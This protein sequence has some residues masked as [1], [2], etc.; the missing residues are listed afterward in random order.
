M[1]SEK[2]HIVFFRRTSMTALIAVYLLILV[3]GIVRSTG[4]GMGCPDWPKCF[5]T[6]IPPTS[7]SQLSETYKEDFVEYRKQKNQRFANY[8]YA[9]GF[10][11]KADQVLN[12][13]S[14]LAE[15]E[16]NMSKTWTEYINRLIGAIIGL[17]I[18]L[19][20]VAALPYY[21][22]DKSLFTL[23]LLLV[24]LVVFQGWIGS[25]VVS[26]NLLPW[27][28]TVHMLLA[29]LI[30][31][32]LI[33]LVHRIRSGQYVIQ[34]FPKRKMLNLL[35]V[36][37]GILVVTQILFGTQVREAIDAV[38]LSLDF[39][40]RD[41]WVEL[42]GLPFMVHRS[43]SILLVA[44]QAVILYILFKNRRSEGRLPGYA[45]FVMALIVLE[46]LTGIVMAYFGIPPFAQP[47]HLVVAMIIFGIQFMMIL[48]INTGKNEVGL[49]IQI[50]G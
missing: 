30:L 40:E 3:G 23:S 1:S 16:F 20:F 10:D 8:L 44:I 4:S 26:T 15:T 9:L 5:G 39:Q 31:A 24:V 41:T 34:T 36:L 6:W 49:N 12:E 17:L 46:A 2:T 25:V 38:S 43:F 50:T 27:M 22:N 18:L 14:V 35:L 19:N 42:A 33:F 28:V 21:K 45:T 29:M 11:Q 48:I 13:Q 7:E 47:M 37:S 32:I